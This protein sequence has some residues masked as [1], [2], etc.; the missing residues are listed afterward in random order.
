[1]RARNVLGRL[2]AVLVTG[3]LFGLLGTSIPLQAAAATVWNPVG[4]P[5]GGNMTC[6]AVSPNF[7]SD[8]TIFAGCDDGG[9]YKSV[10]GGDTWTLLLGDRARAL[11]ISP[12]YATDH[13]LFATTGM[14]VLKS[15]D[16]GA[17]WT[18][19]NDGLPA[20]STSSA[21]AISPDYAND[22]TVYVGVEWG[23]LWYHYYD[24]YA[25]YTG[26]S[27]WTAA[28]DE[29]AAH[30]IALSPN[31]ATDGTVFLSRGGTVMHRTSS[32]TWRPATGGLPDDD[33]GA[34][35]VSSAFATDTTVFVGAAGNIYKSTDGG[36]EWAAASASPPNTDVK[37]LAVSP[38]YNVDQTIFAAGTPRYD[39]SSNG[40][41]FRSTDGGVTWTT[42]M[43]R[44]LRGGMRAVALSPA[45]AG[46][47]TVIAGGTEN[48]GILR[49]TD[50]GDSWSQA[51]TGIDR[52]R[53]GASLVLSPN[54]ETDS[55]AYAAITDRGVLKTAD[56]GVTWSDVATG[57]PWGDV[58]S[59]AIS[60]DFSSDN[61]LFAGTAGSYF[62]SA[63]PNGVYRST[64]AG[65]SWQP[66]KVGADPDYLEAYSVRTSPNFAGERTVLAGTSLGLLR[67][68]DGGDTWTEVKWGTNSILASSVEF[69]PAYGTDRTVFAS[70]GGIYM[71]TN[72]GATWARRNLAGDLVAVSPNYAIDRTLLMATYDNQVFRS[73][74]GGLTWAACFGCSW[75]AYFAFSPNFAVD[76][77]VFAGSSYG[78]LKS[79]DGG[80]NFGGMSDGLP[81]GNASA[82]AVLPEFAAS[83]TLWAATQRGLFSSVVGT[84]CPGGT[85][86]LNGGA[87]CTRSRT[88]TGSSATT[89]AAEMRFLTD[90]IW[91][92]WIDWT[93]WE[94]CAET[95]TFA[96]NAGDGRRTVLA[97]YRDSES[98]I[99][100]LSDT[101]IL[102][103]VGPA[104]QAYYAR[105]RRYRWATLRY[106]VL[107]SLSTKANV[108]IRIKTLRRRLVKTL[109]LNGRLT[110]RILYA[111]FRCRLR[112]GTYRFY[113][114]ATDLAGNRQRRLGYNRLIVL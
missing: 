113:V 69:S 88:L 57:L 48:A 26:G 37:G 29:A 82:L 42:V 66:V 10:N 32:D 41:I 105:V 76:R 2:A 35:A 86:V 25:T 43:T 85:F 104:T 65:D 24:V 22:G 44:P 62:S 14:D 80:A 111:R 97:Q 73:T 8:H 15:T 38:Q 112:R 59:L 4:G 114:Y 74:N 55:I 68:I 19:V 45:F 94:P 91:G 20:A 49:S 21:L 39:E 99:L 36:H 6:V 106:R 79:T 63:L 54:F 51:S 3:A 72:G 11:V 16:G 50:G 9:V 17:S 30:A 89:G 109:V 107:D 83:R 56:A 77:T 61:T 81:E 87:A 7:S 71:S 101:I 95:T 23:F 98:N 70:G 84:Q 5:Y 100:P 13:T 34:L 102:D 75:P 78:V 33:L 12:D 31:Y 53:M 28:G 67:S 47:R 52:V 92:S 64:D 58:K 18:T 103:T 40:G 27:S 110:N 96:I 46:D 60:S 93:E 1:M 90:D 108:V